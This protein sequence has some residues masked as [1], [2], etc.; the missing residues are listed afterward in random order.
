MSEG[1]SPTK[2]SGMVEPQIIDN[3][4]VNRHNLDSVAISSDKKQGHDPPPSLTADLA[5]YNFP[6][7]PR[8]KSRLKE[9][10]FQDVTEI[11]E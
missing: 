4:T 5:P 10:H 6:L 11:Q 8:M 1:A 9:C 7:F 2:M 3:M